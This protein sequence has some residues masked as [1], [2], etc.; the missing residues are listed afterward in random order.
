M[1]LLTG[2]FFHAIGASSASMCYTPERK[3]EY[4]SWQTYWLAQAT[5]CW[6]ILPLIVAWLTIPDLAAVIR[7]SPL[8]S[9]LLTFMLGAAYGIG[10]TAFGIAIRYVGFSL[11]YAFSIGISCVL[12]TLLPPILHGQL[13]ELLGKTGSMWIMSGI[14]LGITGIALCG[15]SG[16]MK[17]KDLSGSRDEPGKFDMAKGM[18][19][20]LLAGVLASFYG[21]SL[22]QGEPIAAVAEKYGAGDLRGNVIYIFSNTGAFLS[23]L[24]YCAYLH[25]R[26][27]T[28][29]EHFRL[30]TTSGQKP[31]LKNY[32][33][34]VLT[35]LLWYSQFFFYGL[36]HVNLGTYQFSSWAIHMIMLVL[37][38]AILGILMKEW[39]LVRSG[40]RRTLGMA[41]CV[42]LISILMITYGNYAGA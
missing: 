30:D 39:V 41:L 3:K 16:R 29:H 34:A 35:G 20:C 7:D 11:T 21:L 37:F 10:G 1:G 38:S 31:L 5:V 28:V 23:T 26:D 42:L 22:D 18:P 25:H 13:S 4:W 40:T 15:I 32:A 33:L 2:V 27:G 24:I 14:A 8:R 12:G 9:M 17:E 36:G 19:L 6:L